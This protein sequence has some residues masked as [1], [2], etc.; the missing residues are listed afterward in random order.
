[1]K[2]KNRFRTKILLFGVKI[3]VLH[4][5][6]SEYDVTFLK[7]KFGVNY[8]MLSLVYFFQLK[9]SCN[10]SFKKFCAVFSVQFNT[11]FQFGESY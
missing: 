7:Q 11:Q 5:F 3:L 6:F 9:V 1:M 4:L 2:K 10:I 8:F